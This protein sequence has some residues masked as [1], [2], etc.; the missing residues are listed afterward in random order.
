MKVIKLLYMIFVT[1]SLVGGPF[2]NNP[3]KVA[4][5]QATRAFKTAGVQIR[6]IVGNVNEVQ[7][8]V[9]RIK[10]GMDEM[11]RAVYAPRSPFSRLKRIMNNLEQFQS[12]VPNLQDIPVSDLERLLSGTSRRDELLKKIS[13]ERQQVVARAFYD[14]YDALIFEMDTVVIH[15]M[16]H[17]MRQTLYEIAGMLDT[18]AH[19]RDYAGSFSGE[20]LDLDLVHRMREVSS[21]VRGMASKLNEIMQGG[22]RSIKSER[23]QFAADLLKNRE[24]IGVMSDALLA[25]SSAINIVVPRIQLDLKSM[26]RVKNNL[27]RAATLMQKRLIRVLLKA[28]KGNAGQDLSSVADAEIKTMMKGLHGPIIG[29]LRSMADV[30]EKVVLGTQEGLKGINAFKTYIGFDVV[31]PVVRLDIDALP[32]LIRELSRTLTQL[33][34]ALGG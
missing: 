5:E 21:A 1:G 24:K 26:T 28:H 34:S 12:N 6:G 4:Q 23:E 9:G 11:Q 8:V 15:T 10:N 7:D 13:N 22:S 18:V 16:L 17:H 3:R 29:L 32:K 30:L 2:V 31:N 14:K 33:R 20:V 27:I 19:I 25:S